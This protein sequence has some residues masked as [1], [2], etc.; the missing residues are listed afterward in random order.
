MPPSIVHL[1]SVHPRYDTRI[2]IKMCRGVAASGMRCALV[3]A[4]GKGSEERDGVAIIDA[5]ASSGRL[6]RMTKAPR[7]VL[8][9]ALKQAADVYH[10]HDPELLTIA[11]ALRRTGA[12]VIFDAHE[13]LPLQ[14]SAKPYIPVP[15]RGVASRVA[16]LG[17]RLLIRSVDHVVGATPWITE[18]FQ[19]HGLKATWVA[20]YAESGCTG[21]VRGYD[22]RPNRVS[23]VGAITRRRGAVEMIEALSL[24]RE[25]VRLGLAGRFQ[26]PGLQEDVEARPG[27]A[28]VDYLGF[29]GREGV[30]GELA[31]SRAGL[32][33]IH[34]TRIDMESLPVKLFEYMAA[35]IPV[36]ASSIPH[37]VEIVD[38]NGCGIC[39]D[40]KS[41]A[42]IAAALDSLIQDPAAASPPISRPASRL[43]SSAPSSPP[44]TESGSAMTF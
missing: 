12:K 39:V 9:A 7:R 14:I 10:L 15:L 44:T 6:A 30:L 21:A 31:S 29:V 43:P 33:T 20:N 24:C 26:E 23:Y 35:G 19:R 11:P 32:V 2:F 34:P 22:Q 28:S 25:N 3:V 38:G 5:G 36:V 17:E 8:E 37:W 41:P 27:W 16:A 40:P 1:T 13:D 18:K 42:E 4:D